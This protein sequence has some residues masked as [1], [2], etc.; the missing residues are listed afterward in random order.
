MDG[1]PTLRLKRPEII[2]VWFTFSERNKFVVSRGTCLDVIKLVVRFR[3]PLQGPFSFG[4]WLQFNLIINGEF[5][6]ITSLGIQ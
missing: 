1:S 3:G 5:P 4:L 6:E 2:P